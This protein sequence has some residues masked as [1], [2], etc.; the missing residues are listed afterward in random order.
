MSDETETQRRV[1]APPA[2]V[3][4]PVPLMPGAL[5]MSSSGSTGGATALG[6]AGFKPGGPGKSGGGT[7]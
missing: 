5:Q 3:S 1:Y 6:P 4:E 2:V 7:N